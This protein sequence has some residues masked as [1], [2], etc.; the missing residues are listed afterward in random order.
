[1]KA[2]GFNIVVTL[3]L[4]VSKGSF[5][6]QA[7][8][9]S[10]M[11]AL[12]AGNTITPELLAVAKVVSIKAKEGSGELPDPRYFYHPESDALASTTDG[13]EP[14]NTDGHLEEIDKAKFDEITAKHDEAKA[15]SEA[16]EADANARAV[17]AEANEAAKS[18]S[19]KKNQQQAA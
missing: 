1:M 6:E 3:F 12:E 13:T 19:G 4:P 11:A 14:A 5:A 16:D 15:A 7:A 8:A 9:Y 18:T 17:A 10:A 2:K